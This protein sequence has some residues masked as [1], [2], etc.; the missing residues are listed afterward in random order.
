MKYQGRRIVS[1]SLFLALLMCFFAESVWAEDYENA[2]YADASGGGMEEVSLLDDEEDEDEADPFPALPDREQIIDPSLLSPSK[3]PLF[4]SPTL[5]STSGQAKATSVD[6][7]FVTGENASEALDDH[8][9]HYGDTVKAVLTTDDSITNYGDYIFSWSYVKHIETYDV[10]YPI[11]GATGQ[12]YRIGD[13][14]SRS[15]P[16]ALLGAYLRVEV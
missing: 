5:Q 16:D 9:L 15:Q 4:R 1:F 6:I 3:A 11:P 14:I 13:G 7:E 2:D 10:T 8:V 12:T